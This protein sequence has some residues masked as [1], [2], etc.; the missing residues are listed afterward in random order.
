MT[1]VKVTTIEGSPGIVLP[2]EA[3]DLLHVHAGDVLYVIATSRGIELT[4]S[5]PDD[6]IQKQVAEKVMEKRHSAL[7]KLA[8]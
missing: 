4:T 5:D 7:K 2:Q 1:I 8:E 6:A 3:L